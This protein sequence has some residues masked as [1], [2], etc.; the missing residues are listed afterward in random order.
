MMDFLDQVLFTIGERDIRVAQLIWMSLFILSW[1]IVSRLFINNR[2]KSLYD[3]YQINTPQQVKLKRILGLLLLFT[4]LILGAWLFRLDSELFV[5]NGKSITILHIIKALCV[6]QAARLL[7]WTINN[8]FIHRY[9]QNKELIKEQR[10][11]KREGTPSLQDQEKGTSMIVQYIVYVLAFIFIMRS[12]DLDYTLDTYQIGEGQTIDFRISKIFFAILI[13]LCARLIVSLVINI[14]LYGFYANKKIDEGSQYAINQLLKY[15]IYVIAFILA[16]ST[17]GINMTLL[18]G[19]AA[20]LL[21]GV[22]LGLQQTFNDFISGIVLLFERSI[23][24]GDM[25]DV[26]VTEGKVQKIGLRASVI[27]TL[28]NKTIVVPNSRIV[29]DVVNNW[30]HFDP[31][32]RFDVSIGVAYGSDTALVKKILLEA[33]DNIER[34]LSRPSPFVRFREFQDSALLFTVY[35]FTN[36]HRLHEDIKSDI[37]FEIDR[38]FREHSISIPFPQQDIW[39]RDRGEG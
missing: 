25:I 27:E 30:S 11:K 6:L 3:N 15:V 18:L 1:V 21:V 13:L 26:G 23:S 8:I 9:Y 19:G 2:I 7:D 32:V 38:L 5:I 16:L 28:E 36:E 14:I 33:V 29:N 12:F 22:G 37:R 39:I 35:F 17:L 10:R 24:V 31:M 20:A 34:V 4:S